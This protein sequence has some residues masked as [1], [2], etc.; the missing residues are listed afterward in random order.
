MGF[1]SWFRAEF[2]ATP[3]S[4]GRVCCCRTTSDMY[5][6]VPSCQ[7]I[8]TFCSDLCIRSPKHG[9]GYRDPVNTCEEKPCNTLLGIPG[10]YNRSLI[11]HGLHLRASVVSYYY[12]SESLCYIYV[13]LYSA[14]YVYRYE[15]S[16]SS[17]RVLSNVSNL[18]FKYVYLRWRN[19]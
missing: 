6:D 14:W 8:A 18:N 9:T 11:L 2:G 19:V 7:R 15:I 16:L 17:A 10:T 13:Q 1:I 5:I 3:W 4:R 12:F